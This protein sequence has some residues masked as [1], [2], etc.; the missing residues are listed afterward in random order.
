[1]KVNNLRIGNYIFA[2][3]P[4]MYVVEKRNYIIEITSL[5]KNESYGSSFFEKKPKHI[6]NFN[7]GK[8]PL[9][10]KWLSVFGFNEFDSFELINGDIIDVNL[11]DYSVWLGGSD[12]CI[13][14]HGFTAENIKYVHE[15]Q[16]LF[17]ALTGIELELNKK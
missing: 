4:E 13:T 6:H 7:L 17:F 1:M 12:A 9:N 8:I 15:L 10:K 11:K 5:N 16:N 3:I 2:N 14:D